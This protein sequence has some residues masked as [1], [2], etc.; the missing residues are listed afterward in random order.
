TFHKHAGI[1][2]P[3]IELVTEG[4]FWNPEEFKP[5]RLVAS[6]LKTIRRLYPDLSLWTTPPYEY[7]YERVPIDVITGGRRFREWVEDPHTEWEPFMHEI[8]QDETQ[9]Q[10]YSR[11]WWL[12]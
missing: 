10:E 5:Y 3:G 8:T 11:R 2:V 4:K 9:W 1:P 12:Y 7:E 6:I